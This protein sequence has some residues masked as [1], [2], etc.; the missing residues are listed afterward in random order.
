MTA[1]GALDEVLRRLR[2]KD[3]SLENIR[4]HGNIIGV[5]V[6]KALAGE[7]KRGSFPKLQDIELYGNSIED[8]GAKAL[9]GAL[10]RGSFPAL[11]TIDLGCNNIGNAGAT[12]LA[13]AL[14]RGSFPALKNIRLDGNNIGKGT[15]QRMIRAIYSMHVRIRV[16]TFLG[17][18]LDRARAS[19]L[20]RFLRRDGDR[21]AMYR[22]LKFMTG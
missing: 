22:V 1:A 10:A 14:E 19:A 21:A 7:L 5:D 3:V 15:P 2:A 13:G 12:A 17:A 9:A 20:K 8:E 18:E 6:A 16:R 11:Q 4:L